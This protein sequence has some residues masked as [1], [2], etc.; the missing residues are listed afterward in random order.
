[1]FLEITY[2]CLNRNDSLPAEF[3]PHLSR[4]I[5]HMYIYSSICAPIQVGNTLA[6][7]LKAVWLLAKKDFVVEDNRCITLKNPMYL[8]I[9]SSTI[10]SI[11]TNIRTD[12]G[13]FVPFG[14]HAIT[15][16]TIHFKKVK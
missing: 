6:P 7:L 8:P 12:E 14:D 13:A 10:N 2:D 9:N 5:D 15:S 1:M 3:L 4:A 11:E 16:L